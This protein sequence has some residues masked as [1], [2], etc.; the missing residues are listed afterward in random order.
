MH[1][2][3]IIMINEEIKEI[4]KNKAN[5]RI[6]S[7]NSFE[8]IKKSKVDI[9]SPKFSKALYNLGFAKEDLRL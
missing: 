4:P 9:N 1:V 5:D 2:D 3:H 8:E 7:F 6:K